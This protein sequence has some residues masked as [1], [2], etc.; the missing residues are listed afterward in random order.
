MVPGAYLR[1]FEPLDA[2]P[3]EERQRWR[4]YVDA[5]AGVSLMEALRTEHRVA[6]ARLLTGRGP[7]HE[8]AALVRRV[9]RRVHLCPLQLELRAATG[10]RELRRTVPD[11]VVEAFVPDP[12]ARDTLDLIAASGRA[13]HILD[14][15]WSIP[16]SWFVLF[17]ADE[18]HLVDP[19]EGRGARLTY[20]TTA[21]QA[22]RRVERAADIVASTLEDG[23]DILD[24]LA[25]LA[26]WVGGFDVGSI[27]ELDYGSVAALFERG[28][29][30]QDRS[31]H[32]VW[33]ALE[34]LISGDV[35]AASAYYGVARSRWRDLR[36]K[37]RAS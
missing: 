28:E 13:P 10:L 15:P 27:V 32:E 14:A 24:E 18:R 20:L 30:E 35:M 23:E 4:S 36:A 1:A 26:R 3:P 5:G 11:E 6:A 29:L 7:L 25:D 2:F 19:P 37:Q 9:G 33:S 31:C 16:L 21:A 22:L 8:D 12:D 34:G 17:E